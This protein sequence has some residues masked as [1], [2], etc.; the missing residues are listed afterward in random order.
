MD[1]VLTMKMKTT[2][3]GMSEQQDGRD[4]VTERLQGAQWPQQSGPLISGLLRE[5]K[6]PVKSVYLAISLLQHVS[7]LL[8]I[9]ACLI[10]LASHGGV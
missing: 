9:H 8:T 10:M 6:N 2:P 1:P 4:L 3:W 7:L 5:K